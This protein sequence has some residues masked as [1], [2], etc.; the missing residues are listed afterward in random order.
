MGGKPRVNFGEKDEA[1]GLGTTGGERRSLPLA[2][3]SPRMT[4]HFESIIAA[5]SQHRSQASGTQGRGERVLTPP[6]QVLCRRL[7]LL[8]R[9]DQTPVGL[10]I[11]VP[12][13]SR[14]LGR[15]WG[16]KVVK[17]MGVC[18]ESDGHGLAG[19]GQKHA[20]SLVQAPQRAGS[21]S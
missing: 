7:L 16:G 8:A 13:R 6:P 10:Q 3:L 9:P 2:H 15:R 18:V 21:A 12:G 19:G 14:S 5:T 20:E 1:V 11:D 17:G 4:L